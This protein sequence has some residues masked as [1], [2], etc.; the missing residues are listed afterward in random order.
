VSIKLSLSYIGT[1]NLKWVHF[2][3]SLN[4]ELTGETLPPGSGGT[5]SRV[6][7]ALIGDG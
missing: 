3:L 5:G 4:F 7:E 2:P 1:S 6:K